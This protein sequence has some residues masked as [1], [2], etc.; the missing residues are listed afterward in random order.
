[1]CGN[2]FLLVKLRWKNK[3]TWKNEVV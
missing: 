3:W 1:M 2:H